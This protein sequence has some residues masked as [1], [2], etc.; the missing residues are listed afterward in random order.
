MKRHQLNPYVSIDKF[1]LEIKDFS[2][3]YL[4][5]DGLTIWLDYRDC[6]YSLDENCLEFDNLKI[7]VIWERKHT[8]DLY[9]NLPEKDMK[10]VIAEVEDYL[11][12]D[13]EVVEHYIWL[14]AQK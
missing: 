1:T 6:S 14:G 7:S 13:T 4:E 9:L 2:S 10:K 3:S 12:K 5:M 8:D 11:N